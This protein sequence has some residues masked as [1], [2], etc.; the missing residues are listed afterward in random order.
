VSE[1]SRGTGGAPAWDVLATYLR[2]RKVIRPPKVNVPRL[3]GVAGDAGL[4]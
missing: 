1:A 4:G 2:A 3:V